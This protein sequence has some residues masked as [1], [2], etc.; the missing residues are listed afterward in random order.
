MY[1]KGIK[2][3]SDNEDSSG[4]DSDKDSDD[5][6]L[7]RQRA[8]IKKRIQKNGV[9]KKDFAEDDLKEPTKDHPKGGDRDWGDSMIR[10]DQL[11]GTF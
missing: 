9:L 2:I 1:Y 3:Q 10:F 7:N 4:K 6:Y 11:M 5:E 8:M